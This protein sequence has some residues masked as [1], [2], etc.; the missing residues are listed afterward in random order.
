MKG[1]S[2]IPNGIPTMST[3]SQWH[4]IKPYPILV[5]GISKHASTNEVSLF[6]VWTRFKHVVTGW[7]IDLSSC[8]TFNPVAVQIT[9]ALKEFIVCQGG[10]LP[11]YLLKSTEGSVSEI[12]GRIVMENG[13]SECPGFK[14][15]WDLDIT[16]CKDCA[17]TYAD[18][19]LICKREVLEKQ[20]KLTAPLTT[21]ALVATVEKKDVAGAPTCFRPGS[22]AAILADF[23]KAG[24]TVTVDVAI[25]YLVE[26][27]HIEQ[28]TATDTVKGYVYEWKKGLWGGKPLPFII[29]V[30]GDCLVY[31]LK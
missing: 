13:K 30:N 1:S 9:P 25:Q 15:H 23:L 26:H 2:I 3:G 31:Q 10:E 11:G 14:K 7:E 12:R 8:Y 17:K 29:V 27:C 6:T 20:G 16:E 5:T 24:R 28:K 22:R 19:Y 4:S 21:P 18:E